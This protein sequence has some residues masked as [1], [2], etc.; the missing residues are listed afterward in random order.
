MVILRAA[1]AG[2]LAA[3]IANIAVHLGLKA[4]VH[5]GSIRLLR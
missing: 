3:N 5:S 2:L 4:F 1:G